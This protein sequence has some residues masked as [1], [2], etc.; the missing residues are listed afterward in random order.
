MFKKQ[1]VKKGLLL[2]IGVVM[3]AMSVTGCGDKASDDQ[4]SEAVSTDIT[5]ETDTSEFSEDSSESTEESELNPLFEDYSLDDEFEK[6][7]GHI[8]DVSALGYSIVTDSGKY[9]YSNDD[10]Q[11]EELDIG[12]DK[13][14][15]FND[16]GMIELEGDLL[17]CNYARYDN[18]YT[19]TFSKND[20]PW[21][22]VFEYSIDGYEPFIYAISESGKVSV[23]D[24][25]IDKNEGTMTLRNYDDAAM[26]PHDES[27]WVFND[28]K[29]SN[30]KHTSLDVSETIIPFKNR[31]YGIDSQ[32]RVFHIESSSDETSIRYTQTAVSI[33]P[34][35]IIAGVYD[36]AIAYVSNDTPDVV[37]F[38]ESSGSEIKLFDTVKLPEGYTIDD[39]D[40]CVMDD[41]VKTAIIK[42]TDGTY[43]ISGS[44]STSDEHYSDFVINDFLTNLSHDE[45]V[46]HIHV[47]A[48]DKTCWFVDTDGYLYEER[49]EM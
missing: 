20:L 39:I 23:Y 21:D 16:L 35:N 49:I 11:Y 43:A 31:S 40:T 18:I 13:I 22:D 27:T 12:S 25:D 10:G 14:V 30:A 4:T 38:N 34:D 45:K 8:V 3:M 36:W 19:T 28:D 48:N 6:Y 44:F 5:T 17:N 47:K 24:L 15:G 33:M 37:Y 9:V 46:A 2:S 32:G 41:T 7:Q 29:D 42:F 1:L 26:L